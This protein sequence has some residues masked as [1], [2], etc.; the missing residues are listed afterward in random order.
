M[1]FILLP[2]PMRVYVNGQSEVAVEGQT[3]GDAMQD[4][5][6]RFPA[7]RPHLYNERGELRPFVNLFVGQVHIKNL[8]Q[9]ETP[10][11]PEDKIRLVAAIAGG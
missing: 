11:A 6:A 1:P 7:M 10:L 2:T 5:M 3:V 4:L 9:L 8:Q